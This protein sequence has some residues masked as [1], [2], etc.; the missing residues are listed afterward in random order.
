M[1]ADLPIGL[2]SDLLLRRPDIREAEQQLKAAN[3]NIG[4]ARAAFFPTISLTSGVGS[5]SNQLEDLFKA[6]ARTWSFIP[7]LTVPIFEAG[8]NKANLD[9]A[10]VKKNIAIVRYEKAIQ[11]RL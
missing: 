8:N 5:A 1:L 2:P 9:V 6:S 7:Q 11:N 3:A 4:A 10:K